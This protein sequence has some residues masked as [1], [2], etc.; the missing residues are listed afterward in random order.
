[1]RGKGFVWPLVLVVVAFIVVIVGILAYFQF[2]PKTAPQ[3]PPQSTP[4]T[5]QSTSTPTTTDETANWQTFNSIHFTF[6]FKYPKGWSVSEII[7]PGISLGAL[8]LKDQSSNLIISINPVNPS[9]RGSSYC[10][11]HPQDT[12]RCE[13]T[14]VGPNLLY[15]VIDWGI[16][17]EANA[18]FDDLSVTL[19]KVEPETKEIFQRILSTFKFLD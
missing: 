16:D 13:Q 17:G 7:L 8:E 14:F 5:P 4:T 2:K 1:V 18:M 10:E 19:H 15:G 6:Q 3:S 9:V 11:I 12:K